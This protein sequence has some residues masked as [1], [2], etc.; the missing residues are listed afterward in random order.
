MFPI[1]ST[2]QPS[3]ITYPVTI[4]Q[5][6]SDWQVT[7]GTMTYTFGEDA[8][9]AAA[10]AEAAQRTAALVEWSQRTHAL[11]RQFE[12]LLAEAG[13]LTELYKDNKI[14]DLLMAL[15][16]GA[17]APGVGLSLERL[18]G[19]GCLFQ[20]LKAFL[21]EDVVGVPPAPIPLGVRRVVITLRD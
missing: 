1:S 17:L 16:T 15:P 11:L 2:N 6:E 10:F 9:G 21:S 7:V 13:L 8:D 3:A 19:I 20:D 4:T 14:I 12:G 18:L 5:A